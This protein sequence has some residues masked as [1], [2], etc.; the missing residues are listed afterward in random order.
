MF[1]NQQN[2]QQIT[3]NNSLDELNI[4]SNNNFKTQ[5]ILDSFY[6]FYT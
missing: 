2:R 3:S 6:T 5:V 1:K 4:Y